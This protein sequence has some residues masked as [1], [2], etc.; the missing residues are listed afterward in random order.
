MSRKLQVI[1]AFISLRHVCSLT[2]SFASSCFYRY[3]CNRE[4]AGSGD[5]EGR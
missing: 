3:S 5:S 4:A 2:N 1:Q